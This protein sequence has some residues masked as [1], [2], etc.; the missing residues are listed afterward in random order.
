MGNPHSPSGS[1]TAPYSIEFPF[2][3][4]VGPV[5]GTFLGGLRD[6]RIL[7]VRSGAKVLCPA[8]EFDPVTAAPTGDFVELPDS[9][10][11][12][13]WT[14]VRARPRDVLNDDF[15]WAL[16]RIDGADGAMLHAVDT[17]G[18]PELIHSGLRVKARWRAERVG[19]ITDIECFVPEGH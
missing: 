16:I 18:A 7:G 14:W 1:L 3:R 19:A 12:I 6:R 15:G 8:V 17:G 10:T 9:G 4:T 5:V 11:V 13:S 2:S